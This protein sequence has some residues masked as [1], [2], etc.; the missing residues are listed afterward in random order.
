MK[1]SLCLLVFVC[2]FARHSH[3]LLLTNTNTFGGSSFGNPTLGGSLI[4]G[5]NLGTSLLGGSSMLGSSNSGWYNPLNLVNTQTSL[6]NPWGLSASSWG[7]QS[8]WNRLPSGYVNPS[9]ST[10]RT[11][12]NNYPGGVSRWRRGSMAGTVCNAYGQPVRYGQN[13][14][15]YGPTRMSCVVGNQYTYSQICMNYQQCAWVFC[16]LQNC[17]RSGGRIRE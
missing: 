9:A 17:Y 11:Y 16:R 4:G 2:A 5:S 12:W 8:T 6:V 15:F 13:Q 1:I 14:G 3:D 10:L 7:T